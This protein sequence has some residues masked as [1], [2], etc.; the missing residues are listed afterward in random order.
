M[1]N[2]ASALP[3][4]IDAQVGAPHDHNG[5]ALHEGKATGSASSGAGAASAYS[6]AGTKVSVFVGKKP[7]LAKTP[8]SPRY[9]N[10]FQLLPAY[11]HYQNCRKLRHPHILQV[12]AT[13]DTDNPTSASTEGGGGG[14]NAA[15]SAGPDAVPIDS[16][17][18]T[19]DLIV[20][21]E[22][23]VSLG[24][25]LLSKPNNDELAWG[26]ESI[27]RGLHFL[28]NDAKLVHGNISPTSFYVTTSGDVKLWNFSLITTIDPAI[29]PSRHFQEWDSIV[30][31]DAYR[32]PERIQSNYNL[33]AQISGS[34]T[35]PSSSVHGMDSYGL[36]IL[37][38][39]YWNGSIPQPLQKATQRLQ[40]P[41]L[42]MRPRLMPLLKCPIFDT[43]L[44]KI[45]LQLNEIL[46][47][48]VEQKVQTWQ[49]LYTSLQ[50][51]TLSKSVAVYKVLPLIQNSILTICNNESMI[52]QDF[53]RR[54][55]MFR[56]V[57]ASFSFWCFC[58]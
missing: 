30:T 44:Q 20:V 27:V 51:R 13:L 49:N 40:T 50:N 28:H 12:L 18:A 43:T 24:E 9:P 57:F 29:G 3:Y 22:P 37:M 31:P 6:K 1:G 7:A 35:G 2:S 41:N 14:G 33:I 54:E 19:G 36:G 52:S 58:V 47:Q 4:S 21:T 42:K 46:V 34:T 16:K 17:K 11:H 8:V 38:D 5:W 56:F 23:C 45:Q 25:W 26:L 15:T 32:S 53:Y 10:K 48:P 55:G 39:Y